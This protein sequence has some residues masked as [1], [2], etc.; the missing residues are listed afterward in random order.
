MKITCES[1]QAKY[2]IADEKV[3]G[4]VFKIRCKR[5]G[6]VIIVRGDE[7]AS[8]QASSAVQETSVALDAIWH[9]VINGEQYGPYQPSQI[10]EL[11]ATGQ[12]DWEAYVWR[13]GFD[14]WVPA[15]DV[16]ELVEAISGPQAQMPAVSGQMP[17]SDF[18][19]VPA[20]A[21]AEQ[22]TSIFNKASADAMIGQIARPNIEPASMGADPFAED[23]QGSG[24]LFGESAA[25][26]GAD[27][28]GGAGVASPFDGQDEYASSEGVVASGASPRVSMARAMTGARNENSVLFSLKNL[29]ALATG[30]SSGSVPPV[31]MGAPARAGLASGEGSGL[32]DIRALASAAGIGQSDEQFADRDELLSIGSKTGAFGSLGSPMA[33]AAPIDESGRNKMV[34]AILGGAA[35]VAVAMIAVAFIIRGGD[36]AEPAP[37][38]AA[39][40]PSSVVTPETRSAGPNNQEQVEKETPSEGELAAR[41]ASKS[42][43]DEKGES[44][45]SGYKRKKSDD[46]KSTSRESDKK[47]SS[48]K[49]AAKEAETA[50]PVK[51]RSTGKESIDDLLAGALSGSA[52]PA[53][54]KA[55][56]PEAPA[57]P[58]LPTKPSRDDVLKSLRAVQPA[59]Q[60]CAKG[61]SGVAMADIVVANSGRV[62]NVRVTQVTGAVASCIAREVRKA[63]FPKFSSSEFSVSFPFR[64]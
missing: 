14:N 1:C 21:G 47:A 11:L 20:P 57:G 51:T 37:A 25:D 55:D 49:V 22:P 61:Q 24:A 29:Q 39:V 40:A 43:E 16:S 54:A 4:R 32:I 23:A 31:G 62:K 53:S 58:Q 8:Q 64:L 52:R 36:I 10:G 38:V 18:T 46:E 59:V 63:K 28:F 3:A 7:A 12:I 35:F 5:C 6:E 45:K 19:S 2:S 44:R 27:V 48:E 41:A 30:S 56:K 42:D 60:A 33:P 26:A 13:E 15:C 17:A 50:T 9:V 34:F